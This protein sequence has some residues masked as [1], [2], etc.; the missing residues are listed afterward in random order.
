MKARLIVAKR[1]FVVMRDIGPDEC[2]WLDRPIYMGEIVFENYNAKPQDISPIGR[3]VSIEPSEE[4]KYFELPKNAL[5]QIS[6]N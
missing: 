6:R 2:W 5:M 4:A 3:A 1:E